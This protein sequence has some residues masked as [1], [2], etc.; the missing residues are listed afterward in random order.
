NVQDDSGVTS[1][2]EFNQESSSADGTQVADEAELPNAEGEAEGTSAASSGG[3][4][5][6]E[7]V[8]GG[9]SGGGSASGGA[10]GGGDAGGGASG[11]SES[12]GGNPGDNAPPAPSNVVIVAHQDDD[13]LFINPRLQQAIDADESLTTVF[14]TSGHNNQGMDYVQSR[15]RG[16]E[17][18]YRYMAEGAESSSSWD[19]DSE[20]HGGKSIRHC[21]LESSK[22]VETFFIRLPDGG[23]SGEHPESLLKL[24][25]GSIAETKTR[26]TQESYRLNQIVSVLRSIIEDRKATN[27]FTTDITHRHGYDHPDHLITAML[28]GVASA[29]SEVSHEFETFVTYSSNNLGYNLSQEEASLVETVFR[30]Y[31]A[32]D[33]E[34]C[35][36]ASCGT[37]EC[38]TR[39][40]AQWYG[41]H[42]FTTR[43][44]PP[45]QGEISRVSDAATCLSVADSVVVSG[46]CET[47]W[48]W[49][50]DFTLTAESGECLTAGSLDESRQLSLSSCLAS[51]D[52][53]RWM[54]LDNGLLML[55]ALPGSA[56]E[57][58]VFQSAQCIT[59][60]AGSSITMG[61][62][63]TFF[64]S[65]V[66]WSF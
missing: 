44:T 6:S 38:T 2:D 31:A 48:Q 47:S 28:T 19:C 64:E 22:K 14:V 65:D 66:Q 39:P 8:P 25:Q 54:L 36:T 16:I 49:N 34:L 53:Q 52:H 21:R 41:A 46:S 60:G 20:T 26:D 5:G 37:S 63:S 55:A 30:Y 43:E 33:Q 35:S 27:V 12:S 3:A 7:A 45:L 58:A 17:T 57:G 59:K 56:E 24:W 42:H 4:S 61:N 13:L 32:C 51:D 9:G 18:A 40:L 15:E 62:C 29:A 11:G 23:G 10:S 50:E 1:D